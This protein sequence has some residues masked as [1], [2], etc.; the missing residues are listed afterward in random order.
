MEGGRTP[1]PG[2]L[3]VCIYCGR[4]CRFNADLRSEAVSDVELNE[5]AIQDPELVLVIRK[6]QRIVM[7][8]I[9]E[10]AVASALKPRPS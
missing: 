3:S 2:A 5:L 8:L 9:V 7:N 4:V 10:R 6:A 1:T